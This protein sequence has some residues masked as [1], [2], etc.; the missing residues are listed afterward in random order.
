MER[1]IKLRPDICLKP[2]TLDHAAAMFA[3]VSDPEVGGNIGLRTTPTIKKTLEW[4]TNA[5]GDASIAPRAICAV[6]KH[7][8]NV[9]LDRIDRYLATAR[10]SIYI[11][12]A[13]ARGKG[14]GARHF[15]SPVLKDSRSSCS[16]RS[17]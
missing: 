11:G 16:T 6:N 4:I 14:A 17:G 3:W 12:D 8:G 13:G 5:Q 1:T 7:V 2:L 10:L 9:I 15:I